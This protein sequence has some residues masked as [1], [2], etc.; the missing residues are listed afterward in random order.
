MSNVIISYLACSLEQEEQLFVFYDALA[1]SLAE[2]GNNVLLINLFFFTQLHYPKHPNQLSRAIQPSKIEAKIKTF[3]PDLIISFNHRIYNNILKV[4]DCPIVLWDADKIPFFA[5]VDCI[6]KNKERYYYFSF[7]EEGINE[8]L[9]L[10]FPKNKIFLVQGATG[11][12]AQSLQ[13]DKNISF[14]GSKF[15]VSGKIHYVLDHNKEY[16]D[17]KK[18]IISFLKKPNYDLDEFLKLENL[19]HLKKDFSAIDF[20]SLMDNRNLILSY[21][22]DLGLS[23]YGTKWEKFADCLPGLASAFIKDKVFSLKDNQ[24]IYNSSKI[25]LNINHPQAGNTGYSWRVL[26]IMA[27]NGCLVSNFCK[28][29]K[30]F[31][32]GYVDIPMYETPWQAREL[33]E[34][35]LQDKLWRKD[36]VM[37]SQQ[38]I[39]DKGRWNLRFKEIEQILGIKLLNS[40]KNPGT[41]SFLKRRENLNLMGKIT[42]HLYRYAMKSMPKQHTLKI[43]K[44]ILKILKKTGFLS[45]SMNPL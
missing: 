29:I 27:S 9:D 8:Y 12:Q 16:G 1:Q 34:K 44:N 7:S 14:I 3:N 42:N 15:Y 45:S 43:S 38:C 4:V 18:F 41:I 39:N 25:C 32:R 31:T 30:E 24:K 37:G 21:L 23:L 26:D 36:I 13:Q 22:L 33:C 20:W 2:T 11:I 28:G 35:I 19:Q 10:G 17:L 5:G 40:S 6:K